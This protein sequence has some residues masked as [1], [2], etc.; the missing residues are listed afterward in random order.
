MEP[1]FVNVSQ[2]PRCVTATALVRQLMA[3]ELVASAVTLVAVMISVA[4]LVAQM[5]GGEIVVVGEWYWDQTNQIAAALLLSWSGAS[6]FRR[7]SFVTTIV[8]LIGLI[9]QLMWSVGRYGWHSD[10]DFWI[11]PSAIVVLTTYCVLVMAKATCFL[12]KIA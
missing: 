4:L 10:F 3:V 7:G 5:G 11:N 8:F 6:V 12:R 2:P 1:L 9:V